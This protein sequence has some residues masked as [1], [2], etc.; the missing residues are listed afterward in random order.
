MSDSGTVTQTTEQRDPVTLYVRSISDIMEQMR[1]II[2]GL[3]IPV[4]VYT[5]TNLDDLTKKVSTVL[6]QSAGQPAAIICYGGSQ[7][8]NHPRRIS[9]IN[10]VL[11]SSDTRVSA[12]LPSSIGKA[13]EIEGALDR[14][15]TTDTSGECPLT[16]LF[17][18][19][20]EDTI[21]LKDAGASCA[22]V[23]EIRVSD[24]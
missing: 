21:Q 8:G 17:E 11:V 3:N 16:D 4:S 12:G 1:G 22:I 15:V 14:L 23:I 5:G 19:E 7:F 10:I 6:T 13:W 9:R 24:Y 20:G 2:A 18:V